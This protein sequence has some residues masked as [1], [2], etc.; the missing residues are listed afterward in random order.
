MSVG[1]ATQLPPTK[2]PSRS[3]A[4]HVRAIAR[5]SVALETA[6]RSS[7]TTAGSRLSS[8]RRTLVP[9]TCSAATPTPRRSVAFPALSLWLRTAVAPTLPSP[10]ACLHARPE[11]SRT[12]VPNTTR[13]A[14][15][16]TLLLRRPW[17]VV[18]TR[19]LLA[20]TTLVR[21]T[22][23]RAVVVQAASSCTVPTWPEEGGVEKFA[24]SWKTEQR[25]AT[26]YSLLITPFT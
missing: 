8:R 22:A 17:R 4:S 18:R 19:W 21:E 2:L 1:A 12:A 25:L 15:A 5:R 26:K 24:R 9:G 13:S 11:A 6:Y 10:T 3:A 16:A 14:T 23:A 7:R 20:A